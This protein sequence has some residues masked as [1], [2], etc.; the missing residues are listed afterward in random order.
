MSLEDFERFRV[1]V[2][3]DGVLQEALREPKD[4]PGFIALAI[5]L[6]AERGCHFTEAEL[7]ELMREERKRWL[8]TW[9]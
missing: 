3:E 6:G 4:V 8:G 5:R 1:R 9:V 2:L 7:R